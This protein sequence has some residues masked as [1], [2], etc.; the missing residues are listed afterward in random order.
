LFTQVGERP[1]ADEEG[2]EVFFARHFM[3]I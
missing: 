2:F 1:V 3:A